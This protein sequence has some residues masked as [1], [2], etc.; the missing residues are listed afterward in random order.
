MS[1]LGIL[2]TT[3]R[4]AQKELWE[5]SAMWHGQPKIGKTTLAAQFPHPIFV[6]TEDGLGSLDA[7]EVRCI[8]NTKKIKLGPG[9]YKEEFIGPSGW[10]T[11]KTVIH[12]LRNRDH[13]F[14]TLV[15]DTADNLFL[16][17]V[18]WHTIHHGVEYENDGALGYGKGGN[19][20]IR[21]FASTMAWAQSL[22][23]GLIII[24]HST[25][26]EYTD[27]N[28]KKKSRIVCTLPAKAMQVVNGMVDLIFYFTFEGNK[29]VIKTRSTPTYDAGS[30]VGALAETIDMSYEAI[31]Q[32]YTAATNGNDPAKASSTLIERIH[33]GENALAT[34]KIDS[35]E[36]EKRRLQSRKKHAGNE[37]LAQCGIAGLE[38][39]LQHLM[40]KYKKGQVENGHG[41]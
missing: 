17:C 22:P 24:S 25:E 34:A 12:D 15:I 8:D 30:R 10:E 20:I 39:Y 5:R 31:A 29:R 18:K 14:Q 27:T 35:F 13:G 33:K 1:D 32:A 28:G 21:D 2:P 37:D 38:S 9:R 41:A 6:S 3:P 7:F 36:V 4:Q 19:L 11:F 40:T 23:M 26:K 16:Q